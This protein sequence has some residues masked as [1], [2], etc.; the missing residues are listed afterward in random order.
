MEV[1]AVV[2]VAETDPD[3]AVL[4]E[5][6]I[7]ATS[8]AIV[9]T[10]RVIADVE[11][12]AGNFHSPCVLSRNGEVTSSHQSG[13]TRVT[14]PKIARLR[15]N[16]LAQIFERASQA[17][18]SRCRTR[19]QA[20][21]HPFDLN[22]FIQPPART[23]CLAASRLHGDPGLMNI[24]TLCSPV[25]CLSEVFLLNFYHFWFI[26]HLLLSAHRHTSRHARNESAKGD[27]LDP[28]SVPSVAQ[29][30][31][32]SARV[33]VAAHLAISG[34]RRV[35]RSRTDTP[36]TITI[37]CGLKPCGRASPK[38]ERNM[39]FHRTLL[40]WSLN[41]SSIQRRVTQQVS[42]SQSDPR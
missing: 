31:T 42:Q 4:E 30:K 13:W 35:S 10:S 1:P 16:H 36:A 32:R 25:L 8:A 39:F 26:Y 34:R 5:E 17:S 37:T 20:H 22:Q 38:G 27:T 18:P 24:Q 21:T 7:A 12:V 2:V 29:A 33:T 14:Q 3:A 6:R 23:S 40:D 28:L 11:A 41:P 15:S 9:V 19:T